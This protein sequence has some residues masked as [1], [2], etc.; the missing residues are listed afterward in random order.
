MPLHRI[1]GG[2]AHFPLFHYTQEALLFDIA[3]S[4]F[5]GYIVGSFAVLVACATT[6]ALNRPQIFVHAARPNPSSKD[7][8]NRLRANQSTLA[9]NVYTAS[10]TC[11]ACSLS[12][13][14]RRDAILG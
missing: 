13:Y 12:R 3:E 5:L 8:P 11:C 1:D 9:L 10:S 14:S 7:A 2:H 4:P 6:M